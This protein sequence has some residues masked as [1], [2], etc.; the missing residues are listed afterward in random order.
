MKSEIDLK[1]ITPFIILAAF[2]FWEAATFNA[3]SLSAAL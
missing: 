1:Y 3:A 2:F